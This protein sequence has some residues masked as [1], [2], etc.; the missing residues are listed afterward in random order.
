MDGKIKHLE[1]IQNNIT[2][3]NTNSF[4]LKGLTITITAT[5]GAIYAST[6][7][8]ELIFVSFV[9]IIFFWFLDTYYLQQERKFIG[10]YN[11]VVGITENV[12]I[13]DFEMPTT[14][15]KKGKFHFANVFI[16][17]TIISIYFPLLII[18]I[19]IILL[20]KWI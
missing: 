6:L 3:M 9:P 13:K 16:S 2:R 5:L 8:I 1:F 14:K 20:E 10:I 17:R 12:T 18:T 15:Y 11:D 7:K 4:Q 19:L